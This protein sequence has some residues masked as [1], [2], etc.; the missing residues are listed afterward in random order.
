MANVRPGVTRLREELEAAAGRP[1]ALVAGDSDSPV[2]VESADVFVGTEAVL[3]RVGGVDTVVF[4]DVDS[5]LLAPRYRAHE[6]VMALVVRA[7]R[8]VGAASRGGRV[9]VQTHLPDHEVVSAIGS[10]DLRDVVRGELASR[11]ALGLPPFGALAA[12]EGPGA[13]EFVAGLDLAAARTAKG[14]LVRA[15]DWLTL[16]SAL[17]AAPR[18]RG[19]AVRVAVDPPRA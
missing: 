3:H 16:G 15:D 13:D 5:E 8:R 17:A 10:C 2:V 1:V 9:L 12:V 11:A 4:L 6:H 18:T 14:H 19:S 7:V